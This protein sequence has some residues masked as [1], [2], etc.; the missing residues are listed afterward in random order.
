M[1]NPLITSVAAAALFV[2]PPVANAQDAAAGAATGAPLARAWAA[3][4]VPAGPIVIATGS[5]S[6]NVRRAS[7]IA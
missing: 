4:L 1:R 6:S 7:A 5:S 3:R 2:L